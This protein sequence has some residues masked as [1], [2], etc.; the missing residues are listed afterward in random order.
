MGS[1]ISQAKAA[2]AA[3]TIGLAATGIAAV[4]GVGLAQRGT[5]GPSGVAV[6][7]SAVAATVT[8][9]PV[10][11]AV[12]YSV[13]RWKQDDPKCCNNEAQGLSVK[14]PTWTDNGASQEGFP[15]A[16]VYVFEVTVAMDN[17]T[18]GAT[19][20]NWQRPDP[21]PVVPRG[22][23]I[24]TK[25]LQTVNLAAPTGVAA[26]NDPG[27]LVLSWQPV[28][29]ATGYQID[30]APTA[31]GPWGPLVSV[32]IAATQFAYTPPQAWAATS[33]GL[34]ATT[35]TYYRISAAHSLAVSGSSTV[36]PFIFHPPFNPSGASA[37]QSGANVT[38]SWNPV[39][40]ASG[41]TVSAQFGT[42]PSTQLQ[43]SG[44]A[45][46]A[47]FPGL[48]GSGLPATSY[49][50]GASFKVTAQFPPQGTSGYDA[51]PGRGAIMVDDPSL[52]WSPGGEQPGGPAQAVS[53]P[54]QSEMGVTVSWPFSGQ[55]LAYRVD[56][57]AGGSP[58]WES[59][60]CLAPGADGINFLQ[61][62]GSYK[63]GTGPMASTT[64]SDQSVAL[65][66]SN[67]YQ[68]RVTSIGPAGSNGKRVTGEGFATVAM[69]APPPLSVGVVTNAPG[70]LNK[71]VRLTWAATNPYAHQVVSS[72]YGYVAFVSRGEVPGLSVDPAIAG[73]HVFTVTPI[74]SN[75][76][77]GPATNVTVVVP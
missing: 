50:L 63:G 29:G 8:W 7:G 30:A 27:G 46:S 34:R 28:P 13:K 10:N 58:Q 21:A 49:K 37:A 35:A 19:V 76:V 25:P 20:I 55:V 2:R 24:A 26:R 18:S 57:T 11:G 54:A 69:G 73:T 39:A 38:V 16:G 47:T 67:S 75:G 22:G 56:R 15:V 23:R 62:L 41:Y 5:P 51:A 4:P 12:A 14:A 70:A 59:L 72:S 6:T 36:V 31:T 3:F 48:V 66:S 60:A 53:A 17:G 71:F 40:G 44:Q 9:N 64:L 65:R 1:Y 68:Y 74:F 52:C 42:M 43:V 32:P 33:R 77:A 61:N 45:T